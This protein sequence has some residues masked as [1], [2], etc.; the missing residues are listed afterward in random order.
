[1][2]SLAHTSVLCPQITQIPKGSAERAH[3]VGGYEMN[4]THFS[5]WL[6]L[7]PSVTLPDS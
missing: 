3:S 5:L 2:Y 7:F 6:A 4:G 1:M